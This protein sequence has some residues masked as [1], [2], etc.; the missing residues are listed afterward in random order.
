MG[1]EKEL[2]YQYLVAVEE[3]A[4]EDNQLQNKNNTH[5]MI[6][7]DALSEASSSHT[8]NPG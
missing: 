8:M 7:V 1:I 5:N 6:A 4:L 2:L 3:S